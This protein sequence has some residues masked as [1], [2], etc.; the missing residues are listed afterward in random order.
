MTRSFDPYYGFQVR[1][2]TPSPSGS[3]Q[4]SVMVLV[5]SGISTA[6]ELRV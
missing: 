2:A 4:N 5:V 3:V 6:V 1:E